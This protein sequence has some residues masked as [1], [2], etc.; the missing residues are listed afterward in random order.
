[1]KKYFTLIFMILLS[2]FMVHV[3]ANTR[4][5]IQRPAPVQH[6]QVTVDDVPGNSCGHAVVCGGVNS[7]DK[8]AAAM[9]DP[10]VKALYARLG[11]LSYGKTNRAYFAYD[12][13][14]IGNKIYWTKHARFIPAG[15]P[16]LTDGTWAILL[17]CGNLISMESE[18][19]VLDTPEPQD[20]YPPT[21]ESVDL[22]PP[23]VPYTEVPDLPTPQ[24]NIYAP[25][26]PPTFSPNCI[27]CFGVVLPPGPPVS[28]P[29][30]GT[31]ILLLVGLLALMGLPAVVTGWL[32][33]GA[34][35][36][37]RLQDAAIRREPWLVV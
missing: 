37:K 9:R 1:M 34:R 30:P 12:S 6:L 21:F 25:P 27:G 35:S 15:E 18:T 2:L 33:T 17:R 4:P 14:R 11:K 20:L 19:P 26:N 10:I 3:L 29:E 24:A 13:Y 5:H 36:A 31:G 28:T 16:I 8:L 23:D 22:V 32:T 7:S